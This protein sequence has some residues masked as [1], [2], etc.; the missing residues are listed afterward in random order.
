MLE[1]L[2][3]LVFLVLWIRYYGERSPQFHFIPAYRSIE[4]LTDPVVKFL[5][6]FIPRLFK[7]Q[8]VFLL[9][10]LFFVIRSLHYYSYRLDFISWGWG[11]A[12]IIW[13]EATFFASMAKSLLTTALFYFQ[14]LAA[15]LFFEAISRV[16]WK[17]HPWGRIA[18][19]IGDWPLK[20]FQKW[21][22]IRL[23]GFSIALIF[24]G[25]LF[26]FTLGFWVVLIPSREVLLVPGGAIHA[27]L[28]GKM[29]ILNLYAASSVL[30]VL[31]ILLLVRALL[32]WFFPFA[33]TGVADL[34]YRLTDPVL[35]WF[36]RWN[37]RA[38]GI[39]FSLFIAGILCLV[40]QKLLHRLLIWA[41]LQL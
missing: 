4:S 23:R 33:G 12:L 18:S 31:F 14:L 27:G 41:Y 26:L 28:L 7:G 40:V 9:L 35:G 32:S 21:V 34:I 10:L 20:L 30:S 36:S 8:E 1:A 24:L 37:W 3:N 2:L 38:G 17:E 6:R 25:T 15:I 39:D 13:K 29:A 16:A 22:P 19:R 11:P 5:S